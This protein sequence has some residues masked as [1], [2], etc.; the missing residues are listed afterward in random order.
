M[1]LEL[2]IQERGGPGR[3]Q[4]LPGDVAFIGRREDNDVVLPYSFISSRHGRIFR[5]EGG[6]FVEDMGS[7]N[8]I[9]V[10]GEALTPMVPRALRPGDEVQVEKIVIQARWVEDQP[11]A[12]EA[13]ATYHEAVPVSAPAA[14]AASAPARTPPAIGAPATM[15]EIQTSAVGAVQVDAQSGGGAGAVRVPPASLPDVLATARQGHRLRAEQADEFGVW[16]V[17]FQLLG[18]AAILGGIVLLVVVLRV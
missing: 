4:V 5:R 15:W 12:A 7:T 14:P 9:H 16:V 6:L 18:L 1:P 8:G 11:K 3:T 17:V 13:G 10:N 2:R